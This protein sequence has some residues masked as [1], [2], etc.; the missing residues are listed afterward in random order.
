[1]TIGW[2]S[3]KGLQRWSTNDDR[4]V[5]SFTYPVSGPRGAAELTGMVQNAG[6]QGWAGEYKVATLSTQTLVD[7]KYVSSPTRVLGVGT[8]APDGT[9]QPLHA[10]QP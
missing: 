10:P 3:G 6:G 8:Y 4:D 7:G 9:A 5:I 2:P 1:V